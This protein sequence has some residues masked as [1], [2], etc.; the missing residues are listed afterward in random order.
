MFKW[1]SIRLPVL[2]L[3]TLIFKK[4]IKEIVE[5]NGGQKHVQT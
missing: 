4:I 2:T 5:H 1:Y 3:N